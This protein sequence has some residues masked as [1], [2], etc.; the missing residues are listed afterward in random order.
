MRPKRRILLV[1]HREDLQGVRR[2]LLSTHGFAVFSATTVA[3]ALEL[4]VRED[5]DLAVVELEFEA[6]DGV[7]LGIRLVETL[8]LL[9]SELRTLLV[10]DK[11]DGS[12]AAHPADSF[13]GARHKAADLVEACHVFTARKRGPKPVAA[14]AAGGAACA[15]A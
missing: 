8:K 12:G 6:G 13:L 15:T 4:A 5:V 11:A 2:F 1:S 10:S 7:A 3:A 14:Q 9:D